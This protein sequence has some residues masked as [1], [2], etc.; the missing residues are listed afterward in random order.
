MV[1]YNTI[2]TVFQTLNDWFK[3]NLLSLNFAKTHFIKFITNN[4]IEININYD[5]KLIPAITY[6][7]FLG[8][9]VN[10]SLTSTNHTDLFTKKT[11]QYMLL[12][13]KYYTIF[14]YLGSEEDLPVSFSLY[15]VL[16]HNVLGKL[17]T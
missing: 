6:T 10:C 9:T 4:Q 7:K 14:V 17:T 11:K 5:N 1:F 3:H 12:N 15:H 16:W 13:S 8:L 2:N